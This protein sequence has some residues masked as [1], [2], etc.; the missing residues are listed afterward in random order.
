MHID[1]NNSDIVFENGSSKICGRQVVF[2]K[3]H[4]AHFGIL[5]PY[6]HK[7]SIKDF[8]C[9]F[10]RICS[11]LRICSELLKNSFTKKSIFFC[12]VHSYFF[13]IYWYYYFVSNFLFQWSKNLAAVMCIVNLKQL[14]R[15]F[16]TATLVL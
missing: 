10:E 1:S 3:F 11:F 15:I 7:F 2:H 6:C 8:F 13:L 16:M 5:C 9:K 4:L 14:F 12:A